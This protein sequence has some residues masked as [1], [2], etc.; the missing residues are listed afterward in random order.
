MK[1][2]TVT[3]SITIDT[4]TARVTDL[5]LTEG[6]WARTEVVADGIDEPIAIHEA[7]MFIEDDLRGMI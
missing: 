1:K 2:R 7:V 4:E 6:S 3:F 5:E